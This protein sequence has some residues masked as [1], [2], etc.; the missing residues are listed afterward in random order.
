MLLQTRFIHQLQILKLWGLGIYI[1]RK[2]FRGLIIMQLETLRECMDEFFINYK[3]W[4]S[5]RHY[6][7]VRVIIPAV[8]PHGMI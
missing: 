5:V 4:Y 7:G 1:F 8:L 6:C 3:S 2:V